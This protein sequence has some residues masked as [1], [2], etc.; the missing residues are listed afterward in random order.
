MTLRPNFGPWSPRFQGFETIMLLG[1][2]KLSPKLNPHMGYR[3]IS[4][5]PAPRSKPLEHGWP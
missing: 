1:D 5:N 4:L 2:D 3:G